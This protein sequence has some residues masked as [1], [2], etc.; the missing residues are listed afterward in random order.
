VKFDK[1]TAKVSQELIS[2]EQEED[3]DGLKDLV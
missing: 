2:E 1:S 3:D